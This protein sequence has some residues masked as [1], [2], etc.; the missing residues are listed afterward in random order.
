[1][2]RGV[3]LLV[4]LLLAGCA[5]GGSVSVPLVWK[6]T[7]NLGAQGYIDPVKFRAAKVKVE[8]MTD[9]RQAPSLIGENREESTPKPVTTRDDVAAFLTARFKTLFTSAGLKVVDSGET[10]VVKGEVKQFF[11]TETKTYEAEVRVLVTVTDTS[12]KAL[13]SGTS[14]GSAHR[15]GRSYAV[16]NYYEVLSDAVLAAVASLLKDEGFQNA[17]AGNR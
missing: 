13:W 15:F 6:P 5:T 14:D 9:A 7:S 17:A 12:G 4:V 2:I 3:A 16:D 11:V 8:P 10:A 1:M